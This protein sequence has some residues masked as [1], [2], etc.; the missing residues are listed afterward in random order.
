MLSL[1]KKFFAPEPNRRL[2]FLLGI[3]GACVL[4]SII[5]PLHFEEFLIDLIAVGDFR[6]RV[7][8]YEFVAH[9]AAIFIFLFIC[10]FRSPSTALW[11][12]LGFAISY[13]PFIS[14]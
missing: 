2:Y 8:Q 4:G 12:L 7:W 3:C 13:S 5:P 14:L 1:L 9:M 6:F 11:F 10:L